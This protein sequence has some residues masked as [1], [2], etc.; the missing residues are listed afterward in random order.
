MKFSWLKYPIS[1]A[2][3]T[4]LTLVPTVRSDALWRLAEHKWAEIGANLPDLAPAV[5]LQRQLVRLLLDAAADLDGTDPAPVQPASISAKWTRGLPLLHNEPIVIPVRT[6]AI[7]APLCSALADG[8]AGESATHIGDAITSGSIDADSLLRVSLARNQ[9]A[10][11]SSALHMGFAPDLLWLIGELAS[12]PLAYQLQSRATLPPLAEWDRGYCPMCGSWPV[13]IEANAGALVLRCSYCALGW[14]LRPHRCVYCGDAG[15]GFVSASP[16]PAH[17]ERRVDLCGQCSG[18]TKV[19]ESPAPTP[20]PLLAIDD[21]A[22]LDL[23]RGA[24]ERGYRRPGLFDLDAIEP[25]RSC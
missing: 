24:M 4:I 3:Y 16:D 7:L 22:T 19:I 5:A 9:K 20:F 10:I 23:D 8:G 11:R 14:P 18:Y 12:S 13:L 25:Q 6:K 17:G 21:L 15:S 2:N 1:S